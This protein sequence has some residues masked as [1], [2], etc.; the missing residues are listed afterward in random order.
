M[1]KLRQLAK[2]AIGHAAKKLRVGHYAKKAI[3]IAGK[4][5]HTAYH[6]YKGVKKVVKTAKAIKEG[7]FGDAERHLDSTIKHGEDAYN[8]IKKGEYTVHTKDVLKKHAKRLI[9]KGARERQ[10]KHAAME[11]NRK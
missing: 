9:D 5:G 10:E 4:V 8:G 2:K 11:R 3:G 7:R 6:A 1:G